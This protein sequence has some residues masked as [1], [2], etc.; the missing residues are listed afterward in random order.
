[1][2]NSNHDFVTRCYD[3]IS[4]NDEKAVFCRRPHTKTA[5][6]SNRDNLR[7]LEENFQLLCLKVIVLFSFIVFS[8][9]EVY[10]ESAYHP[11]IE[12]L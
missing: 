12:I 4:M 3:L 2:S 8:K 1:M 10:F 5:L 11:F 7:D 6:I 9:D